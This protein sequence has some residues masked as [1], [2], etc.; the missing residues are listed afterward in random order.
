MTHILALLGVLAISFSAVFIRLAAVSPVTAVF[1][2]ATY[3]VPV[4]GALWFT[5][6]AGDHRGRPARVLALVSG[7]ILSFDLG[8]WHESIALIGAGLGTV[9]AN[10]QVVFVAVAGWVLYKE[11]PSAST[12]GIIAAVLTGIALTSGFAR[13]D[14]Y[15]ANPV[16]GVALGAAAGACYAG[17]LMTFRAANRLRGP[18]SG[19]LFDATIGTAIGALLVSPLDP[20]FSLA[21]TW[22][23]H[24]WLI[25]L[26]L[27]SQVA[28]WLLIATALPRLPAVETSILLLGQPVFAVIWGQVFFGE[29]LSAI[30]WIGTALVLAGVASISR[31]APETDSQS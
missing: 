16:L 29:H 30:Q 6:R 22:P 18:T 5:S 4:L 15:G 11:R 9:I 7:I 31:R 26:A 2:R 8:F 13:P 17:F 23:A 20:H 27:V 3:A 14:A 1:Y 21:P 12:F 10:I 28:G 25:A 19:P 24:G